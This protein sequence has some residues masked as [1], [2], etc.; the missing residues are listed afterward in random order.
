MSEWVHDDEDTEQHTFWS[1]S[2]RLALC[3]SDTAHKQYKG[4]QSHDMCFLYTRWS[5]ITLWD[6]TFSLHLLSLSTPNV[7][8]ILISSMPRSQHNCLWSFVYEFI[9]WV[10]HFVKKVA[11]LAGCWFSPPI[12]LFKVAFHWSVNP[13]PA[14][15]YFDDRIQYPFVA[16]WPQ[17]PKANQSA[18]KKMCAARNG[19]G[20]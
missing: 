3:S 7:Y 4:Y 14:H 19:L 11:P 6:A 2:G 8:V 9:M 15:N 20:K 18:S 16:D 1:W 10:W 5:V 17:S 13:I 12:E